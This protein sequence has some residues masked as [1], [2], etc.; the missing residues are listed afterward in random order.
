[1]Q[2]KFICMRKSYNIPYIAPM[3]FGEPIDNQ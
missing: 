1:M 2:Y 3:F